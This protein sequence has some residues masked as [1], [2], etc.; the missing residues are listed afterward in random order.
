MKAIARSLMPAL[1]L[2]LV[3]IFGST[4]TSLAQDFPPDVGTI[5]VCPFNGDIIVNRDGRDF[6]G[7]VEGSGTFQ[8][9]ESGDNFTRYIPIAID[10]TS[11]FDELGT[12]TTRL[13]ENIAADELPVSEARSISADVFPVVIPMRYPPVVTDPDGVEYIG[14]EVNF[15]IDA[16]NSFNPIEGETSRLEGPVTFT[17]EDGQSFTLVQ[18]NANFNP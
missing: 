4:A 5:L 13:N 11:N 9:V 3:G 16:S 10:A 1:V 7:T 6:V 15:L 17:S 2:A 18:L 8:V 12:F 14:G